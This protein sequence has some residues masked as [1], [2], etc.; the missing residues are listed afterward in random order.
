MSVT[1]QGHRSNGTNDSLSK[2]FDPACTI[3]G[4]RRS[5][6]EARKRLKRDLSPDDGPA[7][8]IGVA[9][10]VSPTKLEAWRQARRFVESDR[11]DP[12]D[13]SVELVAMEI[14]MD[15]PPLEAVEKALRGEELDRSQRPIYGEGKPPEPPTADLLAIEKPSGIREVSNGG[16]GGASTV[17][18]QLPVDRLWRNTRLRYHGDRGSP[19]IVCEKDGER[20]VTDNPRTAA[21]WLHDH[22]VDKPWHAEVCLSFRGVEWAP[23]AESPDGVPDVA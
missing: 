9:A 13:L 1:A 8:Q 7:L 21:A 5:G 4:Y 19:P 23:V 16:G 12:A 17:E 2:V 20:V 22:G 3:S 15:D 18:V 10:G 14:G 11:R 6:K